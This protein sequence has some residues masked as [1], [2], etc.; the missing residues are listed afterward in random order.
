MCVCVYPLR[1]VKNEK[2]I[3]LII[4][5]SKT[6]QGDIVTRAENI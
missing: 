4:I 3:I 2:E 6:E 1:T 5:I